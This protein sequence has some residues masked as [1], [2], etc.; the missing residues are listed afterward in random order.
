MDGYNIADLKAH[1]SEVIARVE[2]GESVDIMRRGKPVAT[3]NPKAKPKKKVDIAM[4]DALASRLPYQE[5]S[6]GDFVRQMR[7]SDRY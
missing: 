7:D 5:V 4:L 3:I 2:A 1:L 6:A